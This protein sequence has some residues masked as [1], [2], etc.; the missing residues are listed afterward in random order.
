MIACGFLLRLLVPQREYHYDSWPPATFV[1]WRED[2]TA[3]VP[4]FSQC[5]LPERT[6]KGQCPL[7]QLEID[8]ME[9]VWT[10]PSA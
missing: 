1:Q 4:S 8:E 10:L 3:R 5:G 7:G 6:K 9:H 2:R